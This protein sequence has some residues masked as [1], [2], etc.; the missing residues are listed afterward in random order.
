MSEHDKVTELADG[1]GEH[2]YIRPSDGGGGPQV[3][4]GAFTPPEVIG[5]FRLERLLGRGGMAAVFLAQELGTQRHV[6]LKLMDPNLR[7]DPSFVERFMSEARAMQGLKHPNVVEVYDSGEDRGWYYMATEFIDGGTVASILGTM[8]E[9]PAALAAELMA[10]LLNGLSNAHS[11]GVV[12]RDLKPENLL[13]TSG[14]ILKI[15]DFGIARTADNNKLTKTGMLVGTA[16]YM[17]PEQAKGLRVD[18]RSDLF[19]CGIILYELITGVNPFQSDNPATS[20]TRIL[21]S[22]AP[23]I[24]EVKPTAPVELEQ[25]LER[26]LAHDADGR[27]SSAAEAYEQLLPYVS[28]RRRTQPALVAECLKHPIDMKELL[29]SQEAIALVNEVRDLVEGTAL[30]K[31][32]AAIKLHFALTLDSTNKEARALLDRLGQ[33]MSLRFGAP[34]NPKILEM[35]ELL[36]KEPQSLPLITQL[37]QLYKMEGNLLRASSYLKRYLK[38]KPNDAYVSNQLFQ[39]TGDR[40][41]TGEKTGVI[42]AP[43]GTTKELVAGIK[44]GGFK[45]GVRTPTAATPRRT[46]SGSNQ[47]AMV[48]PGVELSNVEAKNPLYGQLRRLGLWGGLA[49]AF[50]LGVRWMA[51]SVD[52]MSDEQNRIAEQIRQ[53]KAADDAARMQAE[54]QAQQQ[55]GFGTPPPEND[56][57]GLPKRDAMRQRFNEARGMEKSNPQMAIN[58]YDGLLSEFPKSAVPAYFRRGKLLLEMR[59]N[60]DA[61]MD[62]DLFLQKLPADPDAPEAQLRLAQARANNLQR[63]EARLGYETFLRDYPSSPLVTE[64]KLLRGELSMLE[65]KDEEARRDFETVISS[66]PR[67]STLREKAEKMLSQLAPPPGGA[68]PQ[69]AP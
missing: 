13:M 7:A 60:N 47:P 34:Q 16:G 19:T 26:L 50:I 20:I 64:A 12:H 27:F 48:L 54:L 67:G 41:R 39:L 57:F 52:R 40:A 6:A 43:S 63:D 62:F 31:N 2:T 8:K 42:A 24:H 38:L 59:R 61:A 5:K 10:Q 36:K 25:M 1:G 65:Q 3:A 55:Q 35:E 44:T 30:D 56:A 66:E 11:A 58:T 9:L 18:A 15:A 46:V 14:G 51:K 28:E 29:D 69:N 68:P 4:P 49:L 22:A 33:G 37:A 21:T 17:S 23:P 32:R 45:A 53:R